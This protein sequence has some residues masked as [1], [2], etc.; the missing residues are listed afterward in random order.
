MWQVK[1]VDDACPNENEQR[2]VVAIGIQRSGNYWT[3]ATKIQKG[4]GSAQ[5]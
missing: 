2:F 1:A 3:G 4:L 5:Q